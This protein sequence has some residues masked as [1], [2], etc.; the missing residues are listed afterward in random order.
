SPTAIESADVAPRAAPPAAR[1]VPVAL[2][3]EPDRADA[4]PPAAPCPPM[5]VMRVRLTALP[6]SPDVAMERLLAPVLAVESARPFAVAFPVEPESPEL[7]RLPDAAAV[8]PDGPETAVGLEPD[9]DVAGPVSPVFVAEDWAVTEPELPD[10][11]VG[12]T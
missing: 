12:T 6:V 2:P 1:V 9:A 10:W 4:V 8:A 3:A 5:A 11:A 7:E